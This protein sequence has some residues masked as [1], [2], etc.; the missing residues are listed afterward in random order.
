MKLNIENPNKLVEVYK[1][2]I[3]QWVMWYR[4]EN[5]KVYKFGLNTDKKLK[6]DEF[7][8][9]IGKTI[10]VGLDD[11]TGLK[12]KYVVLKLRFV[13]S[14]DSVKRE[15]KLRWFKDVETFIEIFTEEFLEELMCDIM[16]FDSPV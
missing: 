3:P 16:M 13:E 10:K 5:E 7:E 15:I 6:N 14:G 11:E 2:T 4:G 12:E 1:T 9:H 8:I